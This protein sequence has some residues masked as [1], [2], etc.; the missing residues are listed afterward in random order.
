MKNNLLI[1]ILLTSSLLTYIYRNRFITRINTYWNSQVNKTIKID[2][3]RN[4]SF[5]QDKYSLNLYSNDN[6]FDDII[7]YIYNRFSDKIN[8]LIYNEEKIYT[9]N[10][11]KYRRDNKEHSKMKIIIPHECDFDFIYNDHKIYINL[12]IIKDNNNNI[13]KLLESSD[14]ST[15]ETIFKKLTIKSDTKDILIDLIDEAKTSIKKQYDKY[16]TKTKE[17]I[18][19]FYYKKDYWSLLSKSPKRPIDT[20][21]LVK[22][23]K[24]NMIKEIQSFFSEDMR[25]T[26]LSFGIPYKSVWMI[27]GPPGSGKTTT[28]KALASELDCDLFI[29]PIMKDMLDTDFVSA[30]SYINDQESNKRI[31]VIEDVDTFFDDRKEGDKN[32]GITLQGFLNCLDGFTCMEGTVLFLTANKPEVLD[33]AFIRSCRID[34]KIELDY[35]DKYQTKNMFQKFLPDQCDRFKDFYSLIQHKQYTTAVLQEFLFYNRKCENILELL[36]KFN[37][38]YEKNEPKNFEILKEENKNFYS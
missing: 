6:Y 22:D 15:Y 9:Y 14:C 19:I 38:I 8:D 21:Y 27:H 1:S 3:G 12:S 2:E 13:I 16:K 30:F 32:N 37:E 24:E 29:L 26:Y 18:R 17:T 4:I 34:H 33:Y 31:I 28:I 11:W 35:A 7:H 36:D 20:I 23:Q 10:D 5:Q 25:N